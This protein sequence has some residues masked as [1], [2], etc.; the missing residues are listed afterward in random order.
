LAMSAPTKPKEGRAAHLSNPA[1]SRTQKR[2]RALG[3]RG[4]ENR[5]PGGCAPWQGGWE[6]YPQNKTR[7]RVATLATRP[8]VGPRTLV[9]PQ[10]TR[11]GKIGGSRG[12]SPPWRGLWGCPPTKS[13]EG[14][15]CHISNPPASGAQN[16][17]EPSAYEGGP[18]GVQ[19]AKPP[20][21]G[22]WG[23]SPHKTK[24]GGELPTLATPPRVGPKTPANPKPAGVGKTGVQGAEPPGRGFGGCA[25]RT[26]IKQGGEL[27]T[28]A[29]PPTSG[30]KN[31]GKP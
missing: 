19:G 30:T 9:N 14:A 3:R 5:G 31:A 24:R 16:A 15:S 21:G 18:R 22:L 2:R 25:T 10:P 8:R 12:A 7:E 20:G 26:R 13:K 4:W 17:G 27:P 28:L 1:A 29:N 6:M 11:V 23:V